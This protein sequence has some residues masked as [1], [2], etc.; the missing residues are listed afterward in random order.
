MACGLAPVF[1]AGVARAAQP[2]D[3][4]TSPAAQPA[5]KAPSPE[6]LFQRHIEAIGGM[7]KIHE[8]KTRRISGNVEFP[9]VGQQ[10]FLEMYQEAPNRLY[11]R[12]DSGLGSVTET[13]Y[14]GEV[15]WMKIGS[16][17]AKKIPQDQVAPII[18]TAAFYGEADYAARY[19]SMQTLPQERFG[20]KMAWPVKVESKTGRSARVLFDPET[21]LILGTD[22]EAAP[23]VMQ[24]VFFQDYKE[25]GGVRAPQT[26][27]QITGDN[28][29]IL[30]YR[31]FE[32]NVKPDRDYF[33]RPEGV[34][35]D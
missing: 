30:R 29:A 25:I 8:H 22:G 26:L 35:G 21:G 23:G 28:T 7:D 31:S 27:V 6:S 18:D 15:A 12:V 34:S 1:G 10:V 20:E 13:V 33:A 4:G 11:L 17:P 16:E 14:D 5:G 24:R 2:T 19:T 3:Q 9:Q 32:V